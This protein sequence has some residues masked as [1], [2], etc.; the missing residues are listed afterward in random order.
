MIGEL[1]PYP[2]YKDSGLPWLGEVP[3]HW[4]LVPNRALLRKRKALVGERHNEYQL[5]S[6]TKAGVIVR[7]I[8]TGRGKFSSDMG[9][10]QEVRKGDLVFCLFDVPETPRTVGLAKHDGMITGAYT[11]FECRNYQ[12]ARFIESFYIAMDDQKLLS[13]LYSGLRN[14]IPPPVFLGVKTPVPPTAEQA[15]IATFLDYADRG[16]RRY[17]RSKQKLIKLLEEQKQVVVNQAVT[18]GLDPNVPLKPSGIEWLGDIPEHWGVW[19]IGHFAKVGNGSTPSRGNLD[20][21][22]GGKYPWLN[23]ASVNQGE[24]T[25]A[26]QF[27][28]NLA[29]KECHLP[30]VPSGSILMAITGQGK[31]RGTAALLSI[32]ATINQHIAYITPK[33]PVVRSSYLKSFLSAAYPELRRLSEASGSTKGALTCWDVSHFKVPVPPI[34]EQKQIEED[35]KQS[36]QKTNAAIER[37]NNELA[38]F[39]EFRTRLIADVVT[40]KLD[41]REA[42]AHLPAELDE[43]EPLEDDLPD[44]ELDLDAD[45]N[46]DAIAEDEAA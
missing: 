3:E 44:P 27:V 24:I 32:E 35:L 8:S 25:A 21:W 37:L 39:R 28:T 1:K 43:P 20:Y 16:I 22:Q 6:L 4:E 30:I 9:T 23:S 40:G 45:S 33:R 41:V 15:A 19:Q 17:I 29:L 26:N 31:T 10:S 46:L 42:A 12:L 34:D 7:D 2:A 18:R 38:L 14:T 36:T 5:L 13:P 11:I